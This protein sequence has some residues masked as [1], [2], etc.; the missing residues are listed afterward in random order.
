MIR[1]VSF[2]FT[3]TESFQLIL[4]SIFEYISKVNKN[5][6][7]FNLIKGKI[8]VAVVKVYQSMAKTDR[9]TTDRQTIYIN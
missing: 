5:G 1:Q 2:D 4:L 3:C 6:P 8:L 7:N 9:S